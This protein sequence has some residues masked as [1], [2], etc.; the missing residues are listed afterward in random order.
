MTETDTKKEIRI[1]MLEDNSADAEIAAHEL[2]RAGL[3]FVSE[4]A[5]KQEA[6]IRML[7]SFRPDI[8][9]SDYNLPDFNGLDALKLVRRT[10]P[11]VPVV[12]VTGALSDVKAVELIRE[13]AKDYVLKD[14][15]ARL[16]PAVQ[17]ALAMEQDVRARKAAEKALKESEVQFRGLVE[18]S[19][20]GI[21]MI[22]VD[23]F[24]YVNPRL[25][26]IFEC[27]EE[28][29][30]KLKPLDLVVEDDHIFFQEMVR[31]CIAG[32]IKRVNDTFKGVCKDG[33]VIDIETHGSW[34]EVGGKPTALVSVLD[35]TKRRQAEAALSESEEKFHSIFD[36]MTEGVLMQL[37]DGTIYAANTSAEKILGFS[38]EQ[39]VGAAT[40]DLPWCAAHED[41]S[42]FPIDEFPVMI[43]IRTGASCHN[44]VM[45]L[46]RQDLSKVW[47]LVN[48][49]P[50][51]RQGEDDPYAAVMTFND[52]TSRRNAGRSSES[53]TT[54]TC[55]ANETEPC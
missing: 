13:G 20:L 2:R 30:M 22:D 10:H 48:S 37:T 29:V 24:S 49:E 6:F 7:D 38:S 51:F 36:A 47:I 18:H 17:Q 26:E 8:V 53:F 39:M 9:L 4:R 50:L 15:L 25:A 46:T 5:E 19:P 54:K 44:R 43:S 33:T 27:T 11:E 35:I 23:G 3:S 34:M 21:A 55:V 45:E 12:M 32:E 41:G 1:L 52:I 16:A 40:A 14:R 31:K 28:D 42:T